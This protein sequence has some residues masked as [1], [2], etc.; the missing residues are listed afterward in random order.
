MVNPFD[1]TIEP[2]QIGQPLPAVTVINQRGQ[3]YTLESLRGYAAVIGF[4]YTR[5][6]DACPLITQRFGELDRVLGSG[7]YRLVEV[8]IDPARDRP[9]DIAAYAKKHG[10][11]SPRWD[12]VTGKPDKLDSFVRSAG[13]SKIDNGKGELVHNARLLLV[14]PD[15]KLADVVA[16]VAWD[17][18][19]VA[20]QLAHIAG[21]T[22]SP[23]ARADFELTKTVAQFC[24]GSY[25]VAAGIIDIVAALLVV[26]A[27]ALVMLWMRR[28][29]AQGA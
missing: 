13:V 25:Q 21:A 16:L 28:V 6:T 3:Q 4:I 27:G 26:T 19:T 20:A 9:A 12:I 2:L 24:G 15:G 5:C 29:F 22:S 18:P 11:V 23:L 17:P 1:V 14:S 8:S 10:I 7:P